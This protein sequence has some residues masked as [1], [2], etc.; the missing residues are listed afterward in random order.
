MPCFQN[1]SPG[2]YIQCFSFVVF[3]REMCGTHLGWVMGIGI[4][5]G[6]SFPLFEIPNDN[7]LGGM[8]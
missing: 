4:D 6:V 3:L 7:F 8:H 2:T 5:G 1:E